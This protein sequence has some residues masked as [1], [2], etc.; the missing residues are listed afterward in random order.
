MKTK[1]LVI[2]SKLEVPTIVKIKGDYYLV[3]KKFYPATRTNKEDE[4]YIAINI[5]NGEWFDWGADIECL[6]FNMETFPKGTKFE[7]EI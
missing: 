5:N 6:N 3:S 4:K 2:A 1:L 7:I